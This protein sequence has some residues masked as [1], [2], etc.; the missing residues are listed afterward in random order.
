[1]VKIKSSDGTLYLSVNGRTLKL[2]TTVDD[3][4]TITGNVLTSAGNTAPLN[5]YKCD[6][7]YVR[8]KIANTTLIIERGD[9][10]ILLAHNE[11]TCRQYWSIIEAAADSYTISDILNHAY[12]NTLSKKFD[13]TQPDTIQ[14]RDGTIVCGTSKK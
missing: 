14:L 2:G 8:L 12:N 11:S 1:M 5:I 3:S 7:E 9:N 4:W 13:V 6:N 10:G